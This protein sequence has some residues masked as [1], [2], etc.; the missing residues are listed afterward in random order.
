MPFCCEATLLSGLQSQ[1]APQPWM[2]RHPSAPQRALRNH[3]TTVDVA[4][5]NHNRG[6]CENQPLPWMLRNPTTTVGMDLCR[7]GAWVWSWGENRN[8]GW[9]L[10]FACPSRSPCPSGPSARSPDP[11]SRSPSP[12]TS[13]C[14]SDGPPG[15]PSALANCRC[16]RTS[17]TRQVPT[18]GA[19]SA[20]PRERKSNKA[21]IN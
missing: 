16:T 5:T 13:T 10:I 17:W 21:M 2:P 15:A 8:R 18:S 12:S 19:T 11:S 1:S 14:S 6:C 7:G 3:S 9:S 4:K 20:S